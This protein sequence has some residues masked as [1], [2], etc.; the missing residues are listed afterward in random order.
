[1]PRQLGGALGQGPQA[2]SPETALITGKSQS[3]GR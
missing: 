1:M 3:L 2:S